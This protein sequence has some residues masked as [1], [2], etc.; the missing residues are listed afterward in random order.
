MKKCNLIA[1]IPAMTDLIQVER[2]VSCPYIFGVRWNTGIVTPYSE[3]ETLV[4]LKKLTDKYRKKFWVDLKGR[5]LRVIEWGNPLYSAIKVNHDVEV[6]LP[7]KVLLR[8]ENPLD[9]VKADKN[10]LFVNPLPKHA[11]G[12]GQS[13][14]LLGEKVEI[15]G[16]LT[17]KDKIYLEFCKKLQ[18]KDV[19]LSFVEGF[20]DIVEVKLL[21]ADCNLVCKIES[22]KGID[23]LEDLMGL[24]F[25]AARDD[26]YI[27]L[28]N[29][30]YMEYALKKIIQSDSEAICASRI[31]TS[32]EHSSNI[33]Y[34]DY[35]DL[36]NMYHLGYTN[37]MLCDNVSNF[38]FDKAI[39][40]WEIFLNE[41]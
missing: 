32:L 38:V 25:M 20:Q 36:E 4:I 9:L 13:V 30:Y 41:R 10:T 23:N 35:E 12:V 1:T 19:M 39:K 28:G 37:F 6:K 24:N 8:G 29:P 26:L 31:F 14:N 34:S 5:Q 16:Y 22:K 11:V 40:G 33:S 18:I 2:I 3:E 7:C 15:Y 21:N 27:E 17:E